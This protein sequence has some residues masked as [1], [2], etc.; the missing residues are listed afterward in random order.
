MTEKRERRDLSFDN[1]TDALAALKEELDGRA[2]DPQVDYIVLTPDRYTQSVER[3]LFSGGGA[4]DCEVLTISRLAKRISPVT[5]LSREGGVMLTS[6]AIAAVKDELEYYKR[7]SAFSG[8]GREAY[9]T[10]LQIGASDV[11]LDIAA[12][13][14]TDRN[15]ACKLRDL[16]RI[17]KAYDKLKND[18]VDAVDRLITLIR[19][20]PNS[21][22]VRRA[23][24]YAIGYS[25]GDID[26]TRLNRRVFDR[27]AGCA[28]SFTE[29]K[30]TAPSGRVQSVPAF[31]APDR[32]SQY[33]Y[34]SAT[35]RDYVDR[36]GGAYG[37]V[38]IICPE[39]RSLLRILNEYEIPVY[40]DESTPLFEQPSLAAIYHIYRLKTGGDGASLVSLCRNPFSGCDDSDALV[41]QSYVT[42]HG[43]GYGALDRDY[44]KASDGVKNAVACA[45]ALTTAFD[46]S[47][48][49]AVKK[50]ID[51]FDFESIAAEL[52]I[53][54]DIVTPV[55]ELAELLKNFGS[56]DFEE[57]AESF[58]AAARALEIK[59]VPRRRDTVSVTL[60]QTLRLS[61]AP[62]LIVADF[63]EGLL[64]VASADD[65]L[66]VDSELSA[67]EKSGSVIEPKVALKN[68]RERIELQAVVI[69]AKKLLFTYS[70]AGRSKPSSF[71]YMI[72]DK[73]EVTEYA[74][75]NNFLDMDGVLEVASGEDIRYRFDESSTLEALTFHA[76]TTGAAREI[77]ARKSSKLYQSVATAVPQNKMTAAGF[78][79]QLDGVSLDHLSA[80]EL[81]DFFTCPYKRFL[82]H[83][84]GLKERRVGV[85]GAPDFGTVV[86]DFME[87]FIKDGTYDCSREK[88]AMLV[89]KALKNKGMEID[90]IAVLG[91]LIDDAVDFAVINTDIIKSGSYIPI[92][93][94]D[95]FNIDLN[96]GAGVRRELRGMIDRIDE[97][98]EHIRIIDY[99]T[100]KKVF[101]LQKCLN[102]TDMQLPLYAASAMRNTENK[103]LIGKEISGVFYVTLAQK[104]DADS[105]PMNGRMINDGD[106]IVEY[107]NDILSHPAS[108]DGYSS[109]YLFSARLKSKDGEVKVHGNSGSTLL[110]DKFGELVDRCVRN[111]LTAYDEIEDGYIERT[112]ISKGCDYCPF[113]GIC[114]GDVKVRTAEEG[115]DE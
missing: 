92:A 2:Y 56:G 31:A 48:G 84:V 8:F 83:S 80:S 24:F 10:L 63:N 29:Y 109:S 65:G 15:T 62:F 5:T 44:S 105:K 69:N 59:T 49:N 9:A 21:A 23:H 46:G 16:A 74:E 61:S 38:S 4:L 112:P 20:L 104:Y 33:K 60:P 82:K 96:D 11:E 1:Y 37:E 115:D 111:A 7:A 76:C 57:D 106:L 75:Q 73:I 77:A 85:L 97:C 50:V 25:L 3:A 39:P 58:F 17:K 41:L 27:I 114:L 54:T 67:L 95:K 88:V 64:P 108:R 89:D 78:D 87:L 30:A 71:M 107:E 100:G 12:A 36:R 28:L 102:G 45:K 19:E 22:L 18:N 51:E 113:G 110:R 34:I 47:F 101:S 35:I 98:G 103:R 53:G 99:K 14:A 81:T 13:Q 93:T 43:V 42:S 79:S 90:D 91:N 86:H 70:E 32:I 6:R 52:N 68:K 94:E 40:A 72:A 66:L 26:T 55:V